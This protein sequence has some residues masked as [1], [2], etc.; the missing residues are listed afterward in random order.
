MEN[1]GFIMPTLNQL[2]SKNNQIDAQKVRKKATSAFKKL[3]DET[4]LIRQIMAAI[5]GNSSNADRG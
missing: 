3:K 4:D 1:D 5:G 2:N